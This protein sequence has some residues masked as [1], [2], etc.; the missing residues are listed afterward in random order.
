MTHGMNPS[1]MAQAVRLAQDINHPD[2]IRY[3]LDNSMYT[4]A[5]TCIGVGEVDLLAQALLDAQ[6]KLLY[7][8]AHPSVAVVEA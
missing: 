3:E 6:A 2:G 5:G 1:A 7:A 4:Q 8:L